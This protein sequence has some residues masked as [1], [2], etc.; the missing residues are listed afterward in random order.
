MRDEYLDG[1]TKRF[2]DAKAAQAGVD[3][4]YAEEQ[5]YDCGKNGANEQN[6]H[7]AI[8]SKPEF[9]KAWERGKARA[10]AEKRSS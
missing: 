8:F 4:V 2:L 6:S 9:T 3:L 10:D 1:T 5:G 7:F